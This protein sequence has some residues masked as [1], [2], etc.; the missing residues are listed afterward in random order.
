MNIRGLTKAIRLVKAA[1]EA[2]LDASGVGTKTFVRLAQSIYNLKSAK[3][4]RG[5]GAYELAV[6]CRKSGGQ[7]VR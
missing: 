4:Q 6:C 2:G 7:R 3:C 1:Q 5:Q